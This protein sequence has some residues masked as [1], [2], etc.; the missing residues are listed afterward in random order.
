MI[1]VFPNYVF[2]DDSSLSRTV[3]NNVLRS[4][5]DVGPQKTR[6]I[7]SCPMVQVGFT[8]TICE[9]SYKDWC[10]WFAKD[11]SYGA[12]WFRLNDPFFGD[13]SRFRLV[14]PE[15]TWIK[16]GTVYQAS[17]VIEGYDVQ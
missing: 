2:I 17:L 15:I 3:M 14:E 12:K 4:E 7:A 5:M 11:I 1:P 9:D 6:P 16:R 8:A 13:G 10:E